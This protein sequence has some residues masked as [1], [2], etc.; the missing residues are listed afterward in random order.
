MVGFVMNII[1]NK[2]KTKTSTFKMTNLSATLK[3]NHFNMVCCDF[4]RIPWAHKH[5][6]FFSKPSVSKCLYIVSILCMLC[7][8]SPVDKGIKWQIKG[9]VLLACC[10]GLQEHLSH[11]AMPTVTGWPHLSK[12][13]GSICW[14]SLTQA[15]LKNKQQNSSC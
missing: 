8:C 2:K 7:D 11:C 15:F 4:K 5:K 12:W 6:D 9:M 14:L 13:L 3:G 1:S 10:A